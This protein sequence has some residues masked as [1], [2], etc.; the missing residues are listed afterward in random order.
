M[1]KQQLKTWAAICLL[2]GTNA[3]GQ[4]NAESTYPAEPHKPWKERGSLPFRVAS[5][6]LENCVD[7][8]S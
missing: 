1:L 7:I 2:I 5:N 4:A 8:H 6:I 3:M